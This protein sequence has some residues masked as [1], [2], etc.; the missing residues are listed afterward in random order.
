MN[1]VFVKYLQAAIPIVISRVN[2]FDAG[3]LDVE[4]SAMLKEQLVK[5]F[6][7]MKVYHIIQ[8]LFLVWHLKC[9]H[10]YLFAISQDCYFSTKLNLMLSSSFSYGGFLFGLINLLLEMLL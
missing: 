8:V 3:R 7:V 5:V 1:N 4:M 6:S 10:S 9:Y 2:Q